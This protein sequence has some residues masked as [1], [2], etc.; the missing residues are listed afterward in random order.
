MITIGAILLF[1]VAATFFSPG[2]RTVTCAT[3]DLASLSAI[4]IVSENEVTVATR[5]A[6]KSQRDWLRHLSNN[7]T[8]NDFATAIMSRKRTLLALM[9]KDPGATHQ[10]IK[11]LP[12]QDTLA[13]RTT[14]CVEQS[15]RVTGVL[16]S[17]VSDDFTSGRST[18]Q[19]YL[20]VGGERIS[21]YNVPPA[22]LPAIGS[23]VEVVGIQIDQALLINQPVTPDDTPMKLVQAANSVYTGTRKLLILMGNY[24]TTNIQMPTATMAQQAAAYQ[25]TFYDEN[26]YHQ[27]QWEATAKDWASTTVAQPDYCEDLG[28]GNTSAIA[29]ELIRIYDPVIDY[30]LYNNQD[31][32]IIA[33][34]LASCQWGA[35]AGFTPQVYQTDE[36][37]I[38][39]ATVS[40]KAPINSQWDLNRVFNHEIGHYFDTMHAEWADCPA[41]QTF[42]TVACTTKPYR[43]PYDI[44]GSWYETDNSIYQAGHY[45]ID[46]KVNVGILPDTDV[47]SINDGSQ[48]QTIDIMPIEWD[49]P[50][51]KGVRIQ[52]SR[53][54][55]WTIE[56]RQPFKADGIT[57]TIDGYMF[58]SHF[59]SL[60]TGALV[61]STSGLYTKS[62]LLLDA[63]PTPDNDAGDVT[64]PVGETL[65][66]AITGASVTVVS[67]TPSALRISVTPPNIDFWLPQAPGEVRDGLT[68]DSNAIQSSNSISANWD[69]VVDIDTGLKNYEMQIVSPAE[70]MVSYQNV[71]INTQATINNLTLTP[72][73]MY[74]VG[75]RAMDNYGNV[76]VTR[77][78]DGAVV[79]STQPPSAAPL[80]SG[81]V[82]APPGCIYDGLAPYNAQ[83]DV[84]YDFTNE[85]TLLSAS[86]CESPDEPVDGYQYKI[87]SNRD[88]PDVLDYT[89]T[90]NSYHVTRSNL[91]LI[92]GRTY[93]FGVRAIR[94][95]AAGPTMWSDGITVDQT[96][97]PAPTQVRDGTDEDIDINP[98]PAGISANWDPVRDNASNVYYQVA[99]GT[100]PGGQE[101]QSYQSRNYTLT[102]IYFGSLPLLAGQT[103]YVSVRAVDQAGNAG[104]VTSSDGAIINP[105]LDTQPPSVVLTSPL[106]GATVRG[107]AN[108]TA[109]ASDDYQVLGVQFLLDGHTLGPEDT[110]PPYAYAWESYL[111]SNGTHTLAARARDYSHQTTSELITFTVNNEGITDPTPPTVTIITPVDGSVIKN[112]IFVV[113]QAADNDRVQSVQL[114][115]DG[116]PLGVAMTLNP[117]IYLWNTVTISDGT[118]TIAAQAVDPASNYSAVAVVTVVVQNKPPDSVPPNPITN[119]RTY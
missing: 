76:G 57:P 112:T 32:I 102:S 31:L 23:T 67:K 19:Y 33:P 49:G 42:P 82:P 92:N 22:N 39:L 6:F 30:R 54:D 10:V 68:G 20:R 84:D 113:V 75:I 41:G 27:V 70:I 111:T 16:E 48:S 12:I 77:Y 5:Q 96:P 18:E 63:T 44:M 100:T 114:F 60:F 91:S 7:S 45:T 56:Y 108:V 104:A 69:R 78:S 4:P 2:N 109:E 3:I 46:R 35:I 89:N 71:G 98:N 25:N 107:V 99:I 24:A 43:D 110:A 66:D 14:N 74:F 88:Q 13:A 65:T 50:G 118:H 115:L 117:F 106:N 80:P 105:E 11:K 72:G 81:A 95:G 64:I 97:P 94:N 21:L 28:G 8:K 62:T 38:N 40:I 17:T 34:F 61:H 116:Q 37:A 86:W 119:L 93:Y 79:V 103:Y 29:R 47:V 36:G 58:S 15:R 85:N 26:T 51:I 87:S 52:R 1:V 59:P 53:S 90:G 73:E 9:V 55:Y 101:L 83:F